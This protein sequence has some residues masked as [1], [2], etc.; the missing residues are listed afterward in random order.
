MEKYP[1]FQGSGCVMLPVA[2]YWALFRRPPDFA[3]N[4]GALL[5]RVLLVWL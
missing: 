1:W 5:I 3:L 2:L 4:L